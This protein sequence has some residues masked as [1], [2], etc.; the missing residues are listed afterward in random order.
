[1]KFLRFCELMKEQVSDTEG[2][3]TLFITWATIAV[4]CF[5][6]MTCLCL[7]YGIEITAVLVYIALLSGFVATLVLGVASYVLLYP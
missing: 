7:I 3:L 6:S 5:S 2:M 1:M 4:A